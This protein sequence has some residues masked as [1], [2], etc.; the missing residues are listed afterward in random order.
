MLQIHLIAINTIDDCTK[1]QDD[2]HAPGADPERG[3]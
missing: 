3:V 1:L 2:L